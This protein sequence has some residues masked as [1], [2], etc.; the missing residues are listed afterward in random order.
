MYVPPLPSHPHH[1]NIGGDGDFRGDACSSG[2]VNQRIQRTV[3][4]KLV[5][6]F[7]EKHKRLFL[8]AISTH[9][10]AVVYVL[11]EGSVEIILSKGVAQSLVARVSLSGGY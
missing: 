9:N 1:Y 10:L 2:R 3:F 8:S 11:L 5:V 6:S 7:E 4:R